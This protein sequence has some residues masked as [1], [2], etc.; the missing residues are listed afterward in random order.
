MKSIMRNAIVLGGISFLCLSMQS[1][2]E[3]KKESITGVFR[4]KEVTVEEA[5]GFEKEGAW[6]SVPLE[7]L[8]FMEE[9]E[10]SYEKCWGS[11]NLRYGKGE[12]VQAGMSFQDRASGVK[13]SPEHATKGSSSGEWGNHPLYPSIIC[14]RV[15]SDWSGANTLSVS[16][17]S[18]EITGEEITVGVISDSPETPWKD[19]YFYRFTVDWKGNK[20]LEIPLSAFVAFEKP[21][22]W[23]KINAVGFFTKAFGYQPSPVT[24]LWLDDLKLELKE[25]TIMELK[26]EG[27]KLVEMAPVEKGLYH[28]LLDLLGIKTAEP[29]SLPLP[30]TVQKAAIDT[31]EEEK[32]SKSVYPYAQNYYEK[33]SGLNHGFPEIIEPAPVSAGEQ[34]IMHAHYYGY[35]RALYGYNPRFQP[36]YVSFD[37]QGKA[38]VKAGDRI[39][40]LD[41]EGK[42]SYCDLGPTLSA[43]G[44][45]KGWHGVLN[46]NG[47]NE[48]DPMIRFDKD[49]DAYLLQVVS[50]MNEKGKEGN[51]NTRTALLLHSRDQMK[52]W[53]VYPIPGGWQASFEKLEGHNAECLNY[54]PV[55]T[56]GESVQGIASGFLIVPVKNKEG[57]LNLEARYPFGQNTLEGSA[58]SGDGNRTLSLNGKVYIVWSWCPDAG[59]NPKIVAELRAKEGGDKIGIFGGGAWTWQNLQGTEIGSTLPPIPE[60]HPGLQLS[61]YHHKDRLE[62]RSNLSESKNGVPTFI[63]VFDRETKLMSAPVFIGMGGYILDGHNTPVITAD[64]KGYLTVL[65]NGHHDPLTILRSLNPFDASVWTVPEY[66]DG[67]NSRISYATITT[68]KAETIYSVNR[69]TSAVYNNALSLLR[70]K[71]GEEWEKERILV[72]PFRYMYTAWSHKM[73]YDRTKDRLYLTYFCN[74]SGQQLHRDFYEFLIFQH[75]DQEPRVAANQKIGVTADKESKKDNPGRVELDPPS[76]ET[77]G[78]YMPE[79]GDCAV[80]VSNDQGE[81]WHLARTEDFK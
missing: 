69:S 56:N 65:I 76:L 34:P 61:F 77:N 5:W 16:I 47:P 10:I 55:L 36:G 3:E 35:E 78:F 51:A 48:A 25:S 52:S 74:G 54:P 50:E 11:R 53:T 57:A 37:P 9:N 41:Q 15:P 58:H 18:E 44:E 20:R 42:W 43:W 46:K 81:S 26:L 38:Y 80:L 49:G 14:D 71:E 68:D 7:L 2:G 17:F 45:R 1:F 79:I 21:M 22:G 72:W 39:Q 66:I 19:W 4:S 67:K 8:S 12:I 31:K 13:I 28:R 30:M 6:L 60:D 32:S 73:S 64:S 24:K 23:N 27:N 59:R 40:W 63:S 70:K 62:E 29:A 75:P 33:P